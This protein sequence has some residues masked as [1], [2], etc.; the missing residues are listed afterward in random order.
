[1]FIADEESEQAT[2]NW[3]YMLEDDKMNNDLCFKIEQQDVKRCDEQWYDEFKNDM[4]GIRAYPEIPQ[5]ILDSYTITSDE[6][7]MEVCI[8]KEH[9]ALLPS[10]T[11]ITFVLTAYW[12]ASQSSTGQLSNM[13]VVYNV[14]YKKNID[15]MLRVLN[16]FTELE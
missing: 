15:L 4:I 2:D 16:G 5:E 8:P 13:D 1:M 14:V 9:T 11:Y 12:G 3:K 7:S 6:L 10:D